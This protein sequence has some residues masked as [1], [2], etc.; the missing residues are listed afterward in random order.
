M[1]KVKITKDGFVWRL[2]D[3][4]DAKLMFCMGHEEVYVLYNDE[5]ESLV[6]SEI[7]IERGIEAGC[8]FGL[9]VGFINNLKND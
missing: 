8:Q 6:E 2:L 5:S 3:H 7:D 4:E 1:N 9:E